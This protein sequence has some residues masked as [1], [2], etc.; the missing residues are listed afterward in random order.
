MKKHTNFIEEVDAYTKEDW[1]SDAALIGI[2]VLIAVAVGII[3][4][5]TFII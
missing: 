3:I 4:L 2:S 1:W 5:E